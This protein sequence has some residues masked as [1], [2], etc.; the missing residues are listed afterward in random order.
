MAM[1]AARDSEKKI[2][3]DVFAPGDA[4]MRS[5]D[6]MR[7]DSRGFY[8]FADRIG[9]SFRWRGENVS[10][11]EVAQTLAGCPG[12]R[13]VNV[14]GVAVPGHEGRAGMAALVIDRG[15]RSGGS[16]R[17][18]EAALPPYARPLFLR[19]SKE[20]EITGTF[21]H[22]AQ[23]LAAQGFDPGTIQDV[24]YFAAA[25]RRRLCAAGHGDARTHPGG[26]VSTMRWVEFTNPTQHPRRHGVSRANS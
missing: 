24:L 9:D 25:G 20:L 13:D 2:L 6:L 16:R 12:V 8:F 3:R 23:A 15:F 7:K 17:H 14:Y 5:G 18:V 21:K 10:T 19:L 1:S 26:G 4:W 22:R 11:F